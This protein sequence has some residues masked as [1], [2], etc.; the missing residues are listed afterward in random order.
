MFLLPFV[1][2]DHPSL[3]YVAGIFGFSCAFVSLSPIQHFFGNRLGRFLGLISYP[4]CLVHGLLIYSFSVWRLWIVTPLGLNASITR[5]IV[6]ALTIV[7]A[8]SAAIAFAPVNSLA[9]APCRRHRDDK[10]G[11]PAT[12][13]GY[14]SKTQTTPFCRTS[15]NRKRSCLIV[16]CKSGGAKTHHDAST[17]HSCIATNGPLD[18]VEVYYCGCGHI[19]AR[20]EPPYCS[21]PRSHFCRSGFDLVRDPSLSDF[22][23]QMGDQ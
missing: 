20:Q 11:T 22:Q 9:I 8:I 5:T 4:L 21:P 18:D 17:H 1:K 7:A 2:A 13:C 6:G 3:T 23:P 16:S 10:R 19:A 12:F 14:G 15:C